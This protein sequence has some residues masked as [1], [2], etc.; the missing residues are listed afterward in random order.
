MRQKHKWAEKDSVGV[1]G[2]FGLRGERK[3]TSNKRKRI[4]KEK[5]CPVLDCRAVVKRLHNHLTDF[6]NMKRKS[7]VYK[8]C[9][10]EAV[11]HS[12]PAILSCES[13][14]DTSSSEEV[15]VCRKKQ[16][17][18]KKHKKHESIFKKVYTSDEG[19]ESEEFVPPYPKIFQEEKIEVNISSNLSTVEDS[20]DEDSTC[21]DSTGEF[22]GLLDNG[23]ENDMEVDNNGPDNI[24]TPPSQ[25][26]LF[27]KF[28]EWLQGPDG[29]RK[30]ERVARQC[31]RHIEMVVEYIDK[32]NRDLTNILH[33]RTLRDKWLTEFEKEKRPGTVKSYLASLNHFYIFL[34][35]E[36]P[37]QIDA[38][39]EML[40]RLSAQVK[41]WNKSF[42]RLVK[43]RF[44]EKR[45]EDINNL[46]TPEQVKGFDVSSVARS[47]VKVIGDYQ[48]L[49][50]VAVPSQVE[51]T[52]VRDYLL[53]LLCI[54]N[55]SQ[56]GV[57]ANMTLGEFCKA[58]EEDGSFVIKIRK[59][60]TFT[61]HG[62]ANI[63]LSPSLHQWMNI[64]VSKFRNSLEN[65]P[66]QDTAEVFLTLNSQPM[67][68]SAVGSQIGS[69]WAKVFGKEAG[70]GG[71]TAFRKAAVSAVHQSD[72]GQREN[73]ASLMDH[74]KSTADKFYLLQTKTT[75][76]VQT[77]KYLSKLMH[78]G[79]SS[80]AD[81]SGNA[82]LSSKIVDCGKKSKEIQDISTSKKSECASKRRKWAW[83]SQ[84]TSQ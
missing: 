55:G 41:L 59:H 8:E 16:G 28:E 47:A 60:K 29:G 32:E 45:L 82:P 12:G 77:S 42:Q 83:S 1:L 73:L 15:V 26:D 4:F 61:T 84:V 35:C 36:N 51:Y 49:T 53:T 14:P 33:K 52:L 39:E 17:K 70:T 64:F 21:E 18:V 54:N 48:D 38:T 9:L 58:Q 10:A 50:S 31:S 23:H 81:E 72:V 2:M 63:V 57:L 44:W 37:P 11:V 24:E 40:S 69:C 7:S 27:K 65:A 43:D 67:R 74:K 30:E 78:A 80:K 19:S 66:T 6:H 79:K 68:P 13:T 75:S 56:A 3:K 20:T 62:H 71:A 22:D 25:Q 5:M 76:A 34:K 46:K